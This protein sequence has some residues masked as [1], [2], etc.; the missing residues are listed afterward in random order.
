MKEKIKK[1]LLSISILSW[2]F[3]MNKENIAEKFKSIL[4]IMAGLSLLYLVAYLALPF[5]SEAGG[6]WETFSLVSLIFIIIGAI[7]L[8]YLRDDY[9]LP[10]F[11]RILGFI[12]FIIFML[13]KLR[14]WL[15]FK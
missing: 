1:I 13:I 15:W 11:L 14:V 10:R 4:L 6:I 2:V 7:L 5:L 3:T 8:F 12:L 9:K